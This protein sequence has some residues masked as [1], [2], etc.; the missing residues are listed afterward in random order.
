MEPPQQYRLHLPCRAGRVLGQGGWDWGDR[1]AR[2]G[3]R[4]V[5]RVHGALGGQLSNRRRLG[6]EPPPSLL[7]LPLRFWLVFGGLPAT[8]VTSTG[9]SH[10]DPAPAPRRE[11][12]RIHIRAQ[13]KRRS[14][15][16]GAQG[17]GAQDGGLSGEDEPAD[18]PP[19]PRPRPVLSASG[20]A[21]GCPPGA[22]GR[23]GP[24]LGRRCRPTDYTFLPGVPA[25]DISAEVG[26]LPL[27]AAS[28]GLPGALHGSL[29]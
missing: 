17:T 13:G 15:L 23:R 25:V 26:G 10:L 29:P 18:R 14:S 11:S 21:V 22:G 7:G 8:V 6:P 1:P 2:W 9:V 12:W 5:G 16:T 3:W 4:E 19:H 20:Q 24:A 28:L 27:P